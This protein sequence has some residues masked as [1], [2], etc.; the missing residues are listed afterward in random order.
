MNIVLDASSAINLHNAAVLDAAGRLAR[1]RLWLTP[2]VVGECQ[3]SLAAKILDLKMNGVL[4]FVDDVSVPTD[5]F[6]N[7]L[8]EHNL[9][10][11]ETE[12]IAVCK[13][14][15]YNF[16]CDDKKARLLAIEALGKGRVVGSLRILRWC[17]HEA[18]FDCSGA[19]ELFKA[20][21]NAGGFLPRVAQPFFCEGTRGC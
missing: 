17:V 13:V 11:G 16:C 18:I 20:M 21:R 6:L 4:Q 14:F 15:G 7:L 19:F 2:T 12:A 9:G 10:E 5:F 3:P 8:A 1:C